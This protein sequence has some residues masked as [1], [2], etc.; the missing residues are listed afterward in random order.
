M[1]ERFMQCWV[2]PRTL[3]PLSPVIAVRSGAPSQCLAYTQNQR[4]QPHLS[5]ITKNKMSHK[6]DMGLHTFSSKVTIGSLSEKQIHPQKHTTSKSNMTAKDAFCDRER[7]LRML[8]VIEIEFNCRIYAFQLLRQ[9][10]PQKLRRSL[11][12][13]FT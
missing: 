5:Q 12:S 7:V 3:C 8:S 11:R 1:R 10:T 4:T 2:L 6:G 13:G 9:P